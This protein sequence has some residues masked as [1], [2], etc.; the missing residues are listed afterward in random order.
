MTS[1]CPAQ[2]TTYESVALYVG[3]WWWGQETDAANVRR[4][5]QRREQRYEQRQEQASSN[6][7]WP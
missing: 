1:L 5:E 6:W 3:N 4:H 7:Y 2:T